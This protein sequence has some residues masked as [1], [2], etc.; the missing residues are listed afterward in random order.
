MS[1]V[2]PRFFSVHSVYVCMYVLFVTNPA[3]AA[4]SNK[5]LLPMTLTIN[6]RQVMLMIHTCKRSM[7]KVS[8]FKRLSRNNGQTDRWIDGWMTQTALTFT[9]TQSVIITSGN[10]SIIRP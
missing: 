6:P 7:S 1:N 5:P 10:Q 4:K 9:Q 8:R 3:V 2:L